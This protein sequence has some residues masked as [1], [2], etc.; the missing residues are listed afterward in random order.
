MTLYLVTQPYNAVNDVLTVRNG[1]A[2]G[3][4]IYGPNRDVTGGG[5]ALPFVPRTCKPYV[6][7]SETT[8]GG[9]ATFEVEYVKE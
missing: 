1:S 5:L 9:K 7:G 2:T 4:A 6:K 3:V 8:S